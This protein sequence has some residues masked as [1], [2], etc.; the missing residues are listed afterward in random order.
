VQHFGSIDVIVVAV[1]LVGI[2]LLGIVQIVRIKTSGDYF[3][4]GRRFNKFLMVMHSLGTG[5]HA[6]DP[7]G[8][9]GAVYER[10][11]SG[12]WYTYIYLF[13]TPFYWIIAPFFRR[14]RFITTADFFDARFGRGLGTL[15]TIMGIVAFSVNTGTLLK[16]TGTISTAV[17]GG[18]VPEWAAI[19]SMTVI[20]VAY[21]LAGGLTATVI[22]EGV[23]GL[24]IIVMSLLLVPF[25]LRFIGGASGLHHLVPANK[26]SLA[27]P[28]EMTIPWIMVSSLIALIGIVAQPHVME[29]CST[30]RTEFEGRVGF[31]YGNFIKR[32]CAMGWAFTGLIIIAMVAGGQIAG[33]PA[34]EH[35]FG[36]AISHLLPTGATGL[37]FAAILAAQMST[38]SAFMVAGSALFSRNLY[39]RLLRPS[40]TDRQI[41][42][43]GR[44]SG[45]IVV[46]AGLAFSFVVGSVAE[47]LTIFWAVNT[48][49]GLLVWSGVLWRRANAAGAWASF[50]AMGLPWLALGMFG[51]VL[52]PAFPG[53]AWLGMYADKAFVPQLV[54]AYLPAGIVAMAIGSLLGGITDKRRLL[55]LG[56]IY[57]LPPLYLALFIVARTVSPWMATA[58]GPGV[59]WD[60][61]L[62][63][64]VLSTVAAGS[65]IAVIVAAL[66]AEATDKERLARFYLLLGT[67]VGHEDRLREAGVDVI[68][69]GQSKGHPWELNHPMLVNVAGFLV[70]LVFAGAIL[71]LLWA[72]ARIGM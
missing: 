18:A 28:V 43:V 64:T 72:L 35:A 49:T 21:G 19:V 38:L 45:L 68:Y 59:H 46:A 42:S 26:F 22:T 56:T 9:T 6:D 66:L 37:M 7:V 61:Q 52:R 15:Y 27:A 13:I 8:V 33:L 44:W 14:S 50:I 34:R 11:L 55:R 53:A 41:L 57:V 20:F 17:T 31:T 10:G 24:L 47:A 1:Y 62:V 51:G 60:S 29:I 39:L 3:T 36:V 54:A 71:A 30:G 69:A 58:L 16:G 2:A 12:I 65:T 40:A 23:Q 48:L 5:T 63:L 67:P 25:G 70:G 32:F 4:G